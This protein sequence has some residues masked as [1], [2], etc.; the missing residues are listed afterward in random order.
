MV[1]ITE[2][3]I[4]HVVG[5]KLVINFSNSKLLINKCINHI[6]FKKKKEQHI[7]GF[8]VSLYHWSQKLNTQK[9]IF[10]IEKGKFSFS[11]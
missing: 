9:S 6:E 4:N 7:Q 1:F 3:I 2:M 10:L 11:R 8:L 5:D